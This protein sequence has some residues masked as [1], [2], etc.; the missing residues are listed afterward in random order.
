LPEA[1]LLY[2]RH[3]AQGIEAALANPP[4]PLTMQTLHSK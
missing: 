3:L 4:A 1:R 2:Q